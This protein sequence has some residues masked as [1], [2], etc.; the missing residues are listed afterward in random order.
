MLEIVIIVI[1]MLF[2]VEYNANKRRA[3]SQLQLYFTDI[4]LFID[5]MYHFSKNL[6]LKARRAG[7]LPV[8]CRLERQEV[9]DIKTKAISAQ[10]SCCLG[11]VW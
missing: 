9:E 5:V 10:L 3:G 8:E 7:G 2:T 11:Y 4:Q 1:I 6:Y